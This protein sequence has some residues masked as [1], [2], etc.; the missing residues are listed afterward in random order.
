[1]TR[2]MN[3]ACPSYGTGGAK[4]R[5]GERTQTDVSGRAE[6]GAVCA[7]R[8]RRDIRAGVCGRRRPRGFVR[9]KREDG[10]AELREAEGGISSD[11]C[12]TQVRARAHRT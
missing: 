3:V 11:F 8:R 2:I 1:M 9:K 10:V 7:H 12:E 4:Y 6:A 5:G